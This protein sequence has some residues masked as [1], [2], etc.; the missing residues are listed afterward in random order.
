MSQPLIN[1]R[2]QSHIPWKSDYPPVIQ[3]E[4]NT[5]IRTFCEQIGI[6]WDVEALVFLNNQIAHESQ[7]LQD[8]DQVLLMI[9][10]VGG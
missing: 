7:I 10:V 2:I 3:V 9:P 1:I 5:T 4:D 6:E 8:N